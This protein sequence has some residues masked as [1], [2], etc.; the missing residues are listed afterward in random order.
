MK[1]S[2]RSV[3]RDNWYPLLQHHSVASGIV[4]E[5]TFVVSASLLANSVSG[6]GN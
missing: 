4:I 2:T 6:R 1:S 5:A 3:G